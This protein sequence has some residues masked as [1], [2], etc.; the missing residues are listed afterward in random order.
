VGAP[1]AGDA[2]PVFAR[3]GE[4]PFGL[5]LRLR[6]FRRGEFVEAVGDDQAAAAREIAACVEIYRTRVRVT[7]NND[8][9]IGQTLQHPGAIVFRYMRVS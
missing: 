5:A 3:L 1:E 6:V 4:Q 8:E 9:L 7:R 2:E